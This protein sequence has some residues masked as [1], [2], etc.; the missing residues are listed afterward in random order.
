MKQFI[1]RKAEK[2]ILRLAGA[3]PAVV[4][5]GPR[6]VGKTSLA[7]HIAGQLPR[8]SQYIDL[9]LPGDFNK[10]SNPELYLDTLQDQTVIIDEVQRVPS[11]FPTLRGLIDKKRQS[12][13]FILLGSA[14]PE[15]IRDTSES[16][17]GRV[18]YFELQPL[19]LE[20]IRDVADYRRH[21]LRGGFPESVLAAGDASSME[22]RENFIQTYLERDL[23][24]LGLRADPMLIRRLWTMAAHL[25]GNLLNMEMLA[26]SLGISAPTVRH[27]LDFLESSYLIRRLQPYF[28]NIKKRIVKSPKIYIRD[29]GILHTLL[30][31]EG[32]DRLQGHPGVGHSWEAY[33]VQ[34]I[35]QRLPPRAEM[36]FYRTQ[37]GSEG[38]VVIA[39]N[40]IPEILVEIKYSMTPKLS[41]GLTVAMNDLNVKKTFLVCPTETGY[42]LDKN[43]FVLSYKDLEQLF[44]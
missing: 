9:E 21:W 13:R 28:A 22:W 23:P 40:G 11:L 34:E 1:P 8:H 43:I 19:S 14:S 20:E 33:I 30:G 2:E 29:T 39:R 35:S 16:L 36:F 44:L 31:I 26:G 24:L 32:S 42:P 4:I 3:F 25:N 38:D 10:L 41:K 17:A 37:D 18:A 27:Y 12:G 6:Q 7:K 15:L 5:V